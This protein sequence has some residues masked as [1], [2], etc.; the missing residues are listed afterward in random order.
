MTAAA[1]P[2]ATFGAISCGT[3]RKLLD[4]LVGGERSVGELVEVALV[5][6]PAVSQH[7]KVLKEAGL[8]DERR[9]GRFR[10]YRLNAAP[11]AGVMD[12]VRVYE[13]FWTG[14]LAALGRVLDEETDN[15]RNR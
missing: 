14:R 5:S 4:A 8:V 11:L 3:R 15:R 7:L 10:R 13:R 12:W 1:A 9:D 2:E 6:Q